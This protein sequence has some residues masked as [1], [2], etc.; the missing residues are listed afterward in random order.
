MIET[1]A[2]FTGLFIIWLAVVSIAGLLGGLAVEFI[3]KYLT[4]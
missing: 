2:E 1:A 4:R 3:I